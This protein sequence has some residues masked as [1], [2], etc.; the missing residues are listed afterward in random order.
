M[1]R[2]RFDVR[3][4]AEILEHWHRGRPIAAI[5][6]SLGVDRKTIRKDAALAPAAGFA[7]GE[8][9]GPPGGWA[10]WLDAAHPALRARSRRGPDGGPRWRSWRATGRRSWR[11]WSTS[12][13]PRP[14]GGGGRPSGGR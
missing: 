4:L 13:P 1:G 6:R 5:G 7:P 14:G 2:R 10:A 8:G 12:P 11:C 3:D 9:P